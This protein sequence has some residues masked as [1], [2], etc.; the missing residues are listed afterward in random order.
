MIVL[1]LLLLKLVDKKDQH[2]MYHHLN[3]EKTMMKKL[4]EVVVV[5]GGIHGTY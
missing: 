2:L 5:L 1:P 3:Q 4:M